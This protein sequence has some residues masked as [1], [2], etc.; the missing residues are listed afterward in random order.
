MKTCYEGNVY[1]IVPD[2]LIPFAIQTK[3]GM[4]HRAYGKEFRYMECEWING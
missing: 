4:C 1:D 2:G 3:K